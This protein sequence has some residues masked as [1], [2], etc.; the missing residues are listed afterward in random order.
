M[1]LVHSHSASGLLSYILL[2][3]CFYHSSAGFFSGKS[4]SLTEYHRIFFAKSEP[5]QNRIAYNTW[6]SYNLG[7][8]WFLAKT[9]LSKYII[10]RKNYV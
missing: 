3:V 7:N 4:L 1:V 9:D 8:L 6:L 5:E 2:A 10:T